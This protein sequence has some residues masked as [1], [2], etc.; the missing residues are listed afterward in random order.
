MVVELLGLH[1]N[2][3]DGTLRIVRPVLP[4][5]IQHVELHGIKIGASTVDLRF[6]RESGGDIV[7][8]V[9]A[10]QGALKVEFEETGEH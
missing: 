1:P 3:F 10:V 6:A 5:P 7:P 9:L 4:E 2:G 8:H